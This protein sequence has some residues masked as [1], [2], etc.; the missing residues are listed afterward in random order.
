MQSRR[1]FGTV[2]SCLYCLFSVGIVTSTPFNPHVPDQ[3]KPWFEGWYTRITTEST[4]SFAAVTGSFPNQD[5]TYPAAFAGVLCQLQTGATQAYQA[6]PSDLRVTGPDGQPI[7]Q[8]P[9]QLS[10]ANFALQATDQSFNFSIDGLSFNM[11]AVV[12][13]ALLTVQGTGVPMTWGP[14]PGDSPEGTGPE[15]TKLES[16]SRPQCTATASITVLMD[17]RP[18]QN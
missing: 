4:L 17:Q 8:Q 15:Q 12:G 3:T 5:L 9:D 2:T 13:T 6:F 16:F 11:S 14:K 18:H 1:V 7:H 10:K